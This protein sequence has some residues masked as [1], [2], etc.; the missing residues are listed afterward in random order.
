MFDAP[1]TFVV[2]AGVKLFRKAVIDA[3]DTLLVCCTAF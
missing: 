1:G 3:G 2:E